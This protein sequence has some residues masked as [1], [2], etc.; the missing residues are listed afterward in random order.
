MAT[1]ADI[2][3]RVGVHPD[4]VWGPNTAAAIWA[5]LPPAPARSLGDPEAFYRAVRA[6][7]G[8]L[9]QTQVDVI[10]AM[11]KEAAHW[12][13]AF[14][15]YG[16]ATAW[17]EARLRPIEE[18]GKGKGRAY[19]KP[20]AR[21]AAKAGAP[22]YG[23]QIPFGRG[24]VQLTW[25]DNYERADDELGLGGAL[26][27]DFDKALDPS[28]AVQ[29]LV[30]GMEEG[31]FTGRKLRDYFPAERGTIQQFTDA[32]RIINGTDKASLIAGYAQM[33]QAALTGG[34]WA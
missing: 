5:A 22:T 29:I 19:G 32:R 12:S 4:G 16:L 11:L 20:G 23:G 31:W 28:I 18:I 21:M 33:F 30:R 26:L 15:A 7:T 9:D 25:C 1:L 27:A 8:A 34:K 24:L 3:R 6:V 2:Q 10:Q 14:L 17:H 13:T